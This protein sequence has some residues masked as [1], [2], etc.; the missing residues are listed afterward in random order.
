MDKLFALYQ[1][2]KL[3]LF[4]QLI[5]KNTEKRILRIVCCNVC[6]LSNMKYHHPKKIPYVIIGVCIVKLIFFPLCRVYI[7][8]I[9]D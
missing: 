4:L 9:L 3:R 1:E 5:T 7:N 2:K 8:V 6:F